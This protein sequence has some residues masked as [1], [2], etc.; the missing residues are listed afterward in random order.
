[1]IGT[2][3]ANYRIESELG[4]GAMG[5][6]YKATDLNLDRIVAIK[7]L[8]EELCGDPGLVERF[9]AEAKA[10]AHLNHANIAMLYTLLTVDKLTVIV[11]EYVEGETMDQMLRRRGLIPAEEAVPLF[12]QALLGIGFAHRMGIIHRDI[13]PNNIMVN[14]YGVVKVMDFGIAKVLGGARL[15]QTGATM[16]TP[17]YMS[18]EQI[19][20]K[21]VDIR[22]DIYSLGITLYELLTAHLPFED[23]SWFQI[24]S[25]HLNTPPPPPTRHYP[26][27]PRGIEQCVLKAVEKSPDAR[28]QTVEEFGSALEH[29][30]GIE[31]WLAAHTAHLAPAILHTGGTAPPSGPNLFG[32]TSFGT[33][34][35]PGTNPPVPVPGTNPPVSLPGANT[36][37]PGTALG[38]QPTLPPT[39]AVA[40]TP[41]VATLPP[42]KN[43]ALL[44]IA[45]IAAIL[46]VSVG[47]GGYALFKWNPDLMRKLTG[48]GGSLPAAPMATPAR[49]GSTPP[50]AANPVPPTTSPAVTASPAEAEPSAATGPPAGTSSSPAPTGDISLTP[51]KTP[52][53]NSAAPVVAEFGGDRK[54][55]TVGQSATLHWSISQGAKSIRIEPGFD[56]LKEH[57]QVEVSPA[58]TTKYVLTAE[59][60]GGK[61]QRSFE[62]RVDPGIVDFDAIPCTNG[63]YH[64][65]LLRWTVKG[66]SSISVEPGIGAAP[67]GP[68][69]YRI[70]APDTSYV[71]KAYTPGGWSEKHVTVTNAP[72]AGLPCLAQ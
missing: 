39:A 71:L 64:M 57:G 13:K 28:F 26:Y 58:Q 7:F 52:G 38:D 14:K 69:G 68:S 10:Q 21:P 19:S 67:M 6:V 59:S 65:W 44:M 27:I 66:A 47:L 31:Q 62:V 36:R 12:R 70:V 30:E 25:N 9:R 17:F 22:S 16:G 42:R 72:A 63:T 32:A 3:I 40:A 2:T 48:I 37:Q 5:V 35:P 53:D 60:P 29:P 15:T 8:S 51:L 46:L 61:L 34:P 23:G 1:M 54:E 50:E 11:M 41:P 56:Q 24:W 33:T 45:G 18:P 20:D 55:I 43:G 4:K 49:E